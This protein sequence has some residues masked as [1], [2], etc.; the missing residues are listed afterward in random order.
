MRY[1][2]DKLNKIFE[3]E[4]KLIE[5][6]KDFDELQAKKE[7]EKN[8]LLATKKEMA[9]AIETAN[10]AIDDARENYAKVYKEAEQIVEKARKEA[11]ELL[12]PAREKIK[13]A[14]YKKYNAVKE[15][16]KQYGPYTVSYTGER[17]YNEFKRNSDWL[18]YMINELFL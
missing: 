15:F 18:N 13:D 14:Q 7:K 8:E 6:E 17:A 4:E 9:T 1:Y 11:E 16:N 5:A 2:S 3:N 12:K 10:L